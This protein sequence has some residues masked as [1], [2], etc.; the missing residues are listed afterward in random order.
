MY[1]DLVFHEEPLWSRRSGRRLALNFL[2]ATI[3]VLGALAILRLPVIEQS[4]P[5]TEL[6]VRIL[7]EEVEQV[8]ESPVVD[9]TPQP[10]E[11]SPESVGPSAA[12]VPDPVATEPTVATD[13]Y[14][15]IPEA[16]RVALD[17]RP[18]EYSINPGFD[19]KRRNAAEQF[20]PSQA[21]VERP[22][23]ENVEKD[24]MGRTLLRSGDCFRV[25]DDPNVGRRDAFLEFGQ[26]M[27]TCEYVPDQPR[28]L[29]WVSELQ[30][31]REG[32]ARYGHPAA[33]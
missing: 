28:L 9:T 30:N 14:A 29:P 5:V 17:A 16:V 3:I 22:I 24:T 32:Q 18:K 7:V 27:V 1:A 26:Y 21:P 12:S 19:E 10:V 31:R 23:W 13:W 33:E 15:L 11:S 25:L 20:A 8:L 2:P 6:I 4:L